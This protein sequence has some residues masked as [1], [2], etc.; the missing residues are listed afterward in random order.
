[1]RDSRIL[2]P[3]TIA[4]GVIVVVLL[5]GLVLYSLALGKAFRGWGPPPEPSPTPIPTSAPSTPAPVST[6]TPTP[7]NLAPAPSGLRVTAV[8]ETTV[9][10]SWDSIPGAREYLVQRPFR[11]PSSGEVHPPLFER[12]STTDTVYADCCMDPGKPYYF[13]VRA[14]GDG[15]RYDAYLFGN[16]SDIVVTTLL[17]DAITPQPEDRAR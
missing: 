17:E 7:S 15:T 10:L 11:P 9:S 2:D 16:P 1:M 5:V 12:A 3:I 13:R 8:T 6:P 14:R 4:L